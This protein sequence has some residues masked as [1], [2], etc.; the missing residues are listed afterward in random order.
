MFKISRSSLLVILGFVY[1]GIWLCVLDKP[2]LSV[3][4]IF[5]FL[6]FKIKILIYLAIPIFTII[7]LLLINLNLNYIKD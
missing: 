7:T 4:I 5:I 3:F 6:F 2:I 1:V